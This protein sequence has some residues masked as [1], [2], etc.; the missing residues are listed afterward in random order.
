M[1]RR[2]F[3]V[4]SVLALVL[5]E[6][7]VALGVRSYWYV[8]YADSHIYW[9]TPGRGERQAY[10]AVSYAGG[11]CYARLRDGTDDPEAARLFAASR[12]GSRFDARAI[13]TR[14]SA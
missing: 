12:S 14:K 1:L 7:V 8:S 3:F 5:N 9:N 13:G 2:L 11:L 10:W 4:L 6:A